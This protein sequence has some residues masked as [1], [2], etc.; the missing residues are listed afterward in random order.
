MPLSQIRDKPLAN[1]LEN[2]TFPT[3][4]DIYYAATVQI[5]AIDVGNF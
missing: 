1:I 5:D 2:Q 3:S 4:Y